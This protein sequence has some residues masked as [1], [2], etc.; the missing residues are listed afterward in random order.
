MALCEAA[1][2]YKKKG[3]TLWDAMIEMYD[4]YGYYKE[5]IQAITLAGKEGIEKIQATMEQLRNDAPTKFGDYTVEVAKDYKT[6]KIKNLVTG[7][8]SETGLPSS[9]VLYYNLNDGAWIC[10]R[11][12]GT[13]PK[14]KF[15]YGVKADSLE[16]ANA[17]EKKLGE[18]VLET[19]NKML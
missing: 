14:I 17:A 13:E 5:G 2:Y 8:E 15:Y 4:K 16:A 19:V 1:A 18:K 12:S 10:V 3:M 9:N 11:P 6:G 7:E